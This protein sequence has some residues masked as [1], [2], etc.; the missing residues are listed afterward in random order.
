MPSLRDPI[1]LGAIHAPNRILMAPL[2][3]GRSTKGHVPTPLMQDYYVQRAS[4]GLI[5]TEATG[6][7]QQGL[8]WAYA[9]GLW[10]AEQ[11]AAWKPITAAVHAAGGRIAAQLWHMGR[12]VHPDFLGG[13]APVSSSATTAPGHVRTYS[14]TKPYA[15]ARPLSIG[16][17]PG[18]LDDFARAADNALEAGFDGIQLHAANGYLIDQF[19]RDGVNLRTDS[20]G[21]SIENR[22]RLLGQVAQRLAETIGKDRVGIRLSPNGSVQGVNDSDPHALFAVAAKVLDEAGIAWLE[23]R[24]PRPG[25]FF[26]P[27]DTHPVHPVIRANFSGA[28]VLNSDYH[29]EDGEAA[30][31]SGAADAIA[32]GRTFLANPDLPERIRRRL[33][34]NPPRPQL[35][36]SQG[37]EGYTDYP[38][39]AG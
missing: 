26:A 39:Y 30:V 7:S 22:V 12:L 33:P 37:A 8:G 35:F 4:A 11:V 20:Y 6:I 38:A 34:L 32:F 5:I 36:Y 14:G 9:P 21:G 2:T 29:A 25:S 24:E 23:L 15:P 3:R 17:I 28:L 31:A 18:L 27:P 10:S 16:E 19:L 1:R 13:A